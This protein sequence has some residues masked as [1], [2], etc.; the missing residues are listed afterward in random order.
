MTTVI[1][2]LLNTTICLSNSSEIEFVNLFP[3]NIIC[4]FSYT[5]LVLYLQHTHLYL[6]STSLKLPFEVMPETTTPSPCKVKHLLKKYVCLKTTLDITRTNIPHYYYLNQIADSFCSA[7]EDVL[8]TKDSQYWM[9]LN[10]EWSVQLS[11]FS[12]KDQVA[13]K[14]YVCT[15]SFPTSKRHSYVSSL[16]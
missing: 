2:L 13:S 15:H 11:F 12:G 6:G 16:I 4:N 1:I 14:Q 3:F 10:R 8:C 9:M 7:T 5:I